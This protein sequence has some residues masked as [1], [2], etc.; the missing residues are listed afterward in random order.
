MFSRCTTNQATAS[1]RPFSASFFFNNVITTSVLSALTFYKS[2]WPENPCIMTCCLFPVK[3]LFNWGGKEYSGADADDVRSC[4]ICTTMCRSAVQIF[5]LFTQASL[6]L[7]TLSNWTSHLYYDLVEK[8]ELH[9]C[10]MFVRLLHCLCQV[11]KSKAEWIHL[12]STQFSLFLLRRAFFTMVSFW[13]HITAACS[14]MQPQTGPWWLPQ[15]H[16]STD[17][18]LIFSV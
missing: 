15:W 2:G 16:Q 17:M 3:Q 10:K 8:S 4:K 5:C 1:I 13:Q 18:A 9:L 11:I 7:V 14:T 6:F 12:V